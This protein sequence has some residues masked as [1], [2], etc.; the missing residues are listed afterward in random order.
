MR[1]LV[2]VVA[3]SLCGVA[4]STRG[5]AGVLFGVD[6]GGFDTLYQ[7]DPATGRATTVGPTD[8][9]MQKAAVSGLAYD[10]QSNTLYGVDTF[11]NR[12]CTLDM[13]T[14][15]ATFFAASLGHQDVAGL[16]FNPATGLLYGS[17]VGTN[18]LLTI[19]PQT[20]TTRS[21]TQIVGG[22]TNIE[23]LAIDPFT[24]TLYG[25]SSD[26]DR[27]LRINPA[28]GLATALPMT[29]PE[30]AW[31]GLAYD[32]ER[33][34]L[35]ASVIINSTSRLYHIDPTTGAGTFAGFI[36]EEDPLFVHGLAFVPGPGTL[37]CLLVLVLGTRRREC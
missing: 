20:G 18:R 13:Q 17:D 33:H 31:V 22:F 12:L 7:I 10:G 36:F 19:D 4:C 23:G 24:S 34:A 6:I 28:T 32:T 16:E 9:D 11:S 21:S 15:H 8:V 2:L 14:G 1:A 29:L 26:Q 3:G 25:L 35:A 27:L 5:V 30:G 37:G